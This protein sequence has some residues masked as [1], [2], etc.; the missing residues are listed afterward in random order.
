M[1]RTAFRLRLGGRSDVEV[2]LSDAIGVGLRCLRRRRAL[3]RHSD[4][5]QNLSMLIEMIRSGTGAG[6]TGRD[7]GSDGGGLRRGRTGLVFGSH[8]GAFRRRL[9]RRLNV[10]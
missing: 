2:G 10:Y 4:V 6:V 7:V 9:R 1:E 3:S 5:S 8:L